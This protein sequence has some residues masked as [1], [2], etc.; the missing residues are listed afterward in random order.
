MESGAPDDKGI[1]ALEPGV[2][3]ENIHAKRREIVNRIVRRYPRQNPAHARHY[4]AEVESDL[5]R[6]KC[7]KIFSTPYRSADVRGADEGL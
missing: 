1:R 7:A 3:E 4:L 6:R 2:A 5:A